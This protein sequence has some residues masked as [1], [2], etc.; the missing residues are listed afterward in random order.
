MRQ[1]I[2][3]MAVTVVLVLGAASWLARTV[4][5]RPVQRIRCDL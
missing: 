4:L 3:L 5:L 1:S 2:G